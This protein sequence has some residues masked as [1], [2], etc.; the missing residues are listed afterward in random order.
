M[1]N[2]LSVS[3]DETLLVTRQ[4]L[5]ESRGY[6]VTSA[7]GFRQGMELCS[8]ASGFELFI[9]GHSI[10]MEQKQALIQAFRAQRPTSPIIALKRASEEL[11][12]GADMSIDPAPEQ[13]LS[14]VAHLVRGKGTTA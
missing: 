2:I 5:L 6:R 12:G 11:V 9:L 1:P 8:S 14:S 13:L 4:R 10:P 7:C 3:Y